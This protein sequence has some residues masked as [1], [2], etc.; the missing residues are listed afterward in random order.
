[1]GLSGLSS[2][3]RG[4]F[5]LYP[6]SLNIDLSTIFELSSS[7]LVSYIVLYY[8]DV[9]YDAEFCWST[10]KL[11]RACCVLLSFG[12]LLWLRLVPPLDFLLLDDVG[13][14]VS[15]ACLLFSKLGTC[16]TSL[17][18]AFSS[19]TNSRPRKRIKLSDIS[20]SSEPTPTKSNFLE[21]S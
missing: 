8:L 17:R 3:I 12:M 21:Y 10:R 6:D 15:S 5:S 13:S 19:W 14:L 16:L 11:S 7:V 9:D 20:S 1:M 4:S 18:L 2:S